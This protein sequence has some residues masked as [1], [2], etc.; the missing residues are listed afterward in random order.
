MGITP[1]FPTTEAFV[2]AAAKGEMYPRVGY[3]DL[4][5]FE[6]RLAVQE[7]APAAL[8]F[9]SGMAAI[10][11]VLKERDGFYDL[12][13]YSYPLLGPTNHLF[14]VKPLKA[15]L[16]PP[17]LRDAQRLRDKTCLSHETFSFYAEAPSNPLNLDPQVMEWLGHQ[18][19]RL[20]PLRSVFR[21]LPDYCTVVLDDTMLSGLWQPY[22]KIT[23]MKTFHRAMGRGERELVIVRSMTKSFQSG[24]D[25][26]TAGVVFGSEDYIKRLKAVRGAT[27]GFLQPVAL[28]Q[29]MQA[30]QVNCYRD[31]AV[32]ASNLAFYLA[33]ALA[34]AGIRV[35]YV[36]LRKHPDFGLLEQ[37]GLDSRTAG[38]VLCVDFGTGERLAK[39]ADACQQNGWIIGNTF[40]HTENAI[41]P[42]GCLQKPQTGWC[43]I[44]AGFG[45]TDIQQPVRDMRKVLRS[46]K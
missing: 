11:A 36:G 28:E 43:R 14:E 1:L 37:Y 16:Y 5:A 42:L 22:P 41:A 34:K 29:L 30:F 26:V 40:G 7:D 25:V 15:M 35:S 23:Q 38:T 39:F 3:Y 21:N 20:L 13:A 10:A 4:S 18:P 46:L 19:M 45:W 31:E 24:A 32:L 8:L 33:G 27:G 2:A 17:D 44:G 12:W 6:A 9:N